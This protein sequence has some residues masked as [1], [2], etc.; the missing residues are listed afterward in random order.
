MD[1]RGLWA[2]I[3]ARQKQEVLISIIKTKYAE[4]NYDGGVVEAAIPFDRGASGVGLPVFTDDEKSAL[5][6]NEFEVERRCREER[7]SRES[8]AVCADDA[9]GLPEGVFCVVA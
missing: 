2:C 4:H 8:F 3:K 6:E 7:R 1:F 5:A 9:D